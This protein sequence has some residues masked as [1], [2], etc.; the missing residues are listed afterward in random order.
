MTSRQPLVNIYNNPPTP[1][2]PSNAELL[3][4]MNAGFKAGFKAV[5]AG[6]NGVSKRLDGVSKRL[7]RIEFQL[8]PMANEEFYGIPVV[9]SE[10]HKLTDASSKQATYTWFN[11]SGMAC[12][13]GAAHCAL[14]VATTNDGVMF[15]ELPRE[16]TD[17]GVLSI[18]LMDPY[19]KDFTNPLPTH[20]DII[21]I[22]V[23]ADPPHG[24]NLPQF[25]KVTPEKYKEQ[26]RSQVVGRALGSI[27][28][29]RDGIFVSE[30]NVHSGGVIQFLL[31]VGEPGDSGTL[32]LIMD[33]MGNFHARAIFC[34]IQPCLTSQHSRRGQA[35]ILPPFGHLTELK[36]VE[37]QTIPTG[38]SVDVKCFTGAPKVTAVTPCINDALCH[39]FPKPEFGQNAVEL[40]D[41][42]NNAAK[43]G[44]F[45]RTDHPINYIGAADSYRMSGQL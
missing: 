43:H 5:N 22:M 15:V 11:Y 31:D 27:V 33:G 36:V 19:A 10:T 25:T 18:Y 23:K 32:L 16:I 29:S 24:K 45:V 41:M 6:F 30:S 21:V 12:I 14:T 42:R 35:A 26:R 37:T 7:D 39:V 28:S 4:A 17:L 40:K 8:N 20:K 13:V 9:G 1:P 3:K 44:V 38:G 2:N 34:G